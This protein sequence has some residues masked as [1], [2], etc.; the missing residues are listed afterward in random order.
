MQVCSSM[1]VLYIY[2]QVRGGACRRRVSCCEHIRIYPYT[3][4]Y[5][6]IST[7]MQVCSSMRAS[8][9]YMQVRGGD[10]ITTIHPHT[11]YIY[12]QVR[13]GDWRRYRVGCCQYIPSYYYLPSCSVCVYICRYAVGIPGGAVSGS[14]TVVLSVFKLGALG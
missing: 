2:M 11:T 1:R 6:Y 14:V 12:I 8:S 4:S 9:I 5:Y 10:W 3:P 13:G 7:Y